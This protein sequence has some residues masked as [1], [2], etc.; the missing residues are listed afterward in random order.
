MRIS[1][2]TGTL[3]PRQRWPLRR[4]RVRRPR[5]LRR[6]RVPDRL[7]CVPPD[8][9]GF[10]FLPKLKELAVRGVNPVDSGCAA[11]T[12]TMASAAAMPSRP[13][14]TDAPADVVSEAVER[15]ASSNRHRHHRRCRNRDRRFRRLDIAVSAAN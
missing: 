8:L 14:D 2:D 5:E 9:D 3:A 7:Q 6:E 1:V 13:I 4:L 11:G 15:R 10:R 12:S